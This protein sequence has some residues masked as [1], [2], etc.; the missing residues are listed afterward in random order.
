MKGYFVPAR[1]VAVGPRTRGQV[2]QILFEEGTKVKQGDVLARLDDTLAKIELQRAE[3]KLMVAKARLALLKAGPPARLPEE[4]AVAEAEC[5]VAE[6]DVHRAAYVLDGMTVR[7]VRGHGS[8][9]TK[10]RRF[11]CRPGRQNLRNG[12]LAEMEVEVSVQERDLRHVQRGQ[13][14]NVQAEA[15][16]EVTYKGVVN[17]LQPVADLGKGA[18]VLRIRLEIPEKDDRL[19]PNMGAVVSFLAKE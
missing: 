13:H 17:R 8:H 1:W 12:K 2:T 5:R 19:L 14:C 15:Y 7:A 16:P 4:L 11:Q 3:A 6:A 9:K 10:Q 18:V